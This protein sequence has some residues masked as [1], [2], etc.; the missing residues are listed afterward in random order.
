MEV[1]GRS[2]RCSRQEAEVLR[3][4]SERAAVPVSYEVITST[5]WPEAPNGV[6]RTTNVLDQL[7]KKLPMVRIVRGAACAVLTC[8]VAITLETIPGREVVTDRWLKNDTKGPMAAAYVKAGIEKVT[9]H[10]LR[11]TYA[12]TLINQGVPLKVIADG[13]EVSIDQ[14]RR[15]DPFRSFLGGGDL[16]EGVEHFDGTS[17]IRP[18]PVLGQ[19]SAP[20]FREVQVDRLWKQFSC[21]LVGSHFSS[22]ATAESLRL[23]GLPPIAILGREPAP[24][25]TF[26]KA[27]GEVRGPGL[28]RALAVNP[29][30]LALLVFNQEPMVPKIR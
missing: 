11:H 10:E 18:Q 12:S 23:G 19:E 13:Q 4:L 26:T 24:M 15:G 6:K 9:F 30:T 16:P 3:L 29:A 25:E 27:K 28:E 2:R 20:I 17:G 5:L 22:P 1:E 8:P 7:R 21:Q 14:E